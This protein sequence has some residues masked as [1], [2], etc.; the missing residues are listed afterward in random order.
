MKRSRVQNWQRQL[1]CCINTHNSCSRLF[2][3]N[4]VSVSSIKYSGLTLWTKTV[5]KLTDCFRA[6]WADYHRFTLHSKRCNREN[7]IMHILPLPVDIATKTAFLKDQNEE[8]VEDIWEGWILSCIFGNDNRVCGSI[9]KM[10][11]FMTPTKRHTSKS[12]DA[13]S[14]DGENGAAA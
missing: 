7:L 5:S 9:F 6:K 10:L 8:Y 13:E 2:L 3:W 4:P 12:T 11:H 1:S 14:C